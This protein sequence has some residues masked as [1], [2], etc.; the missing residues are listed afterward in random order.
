MRTIMNCFCNCH[1]VGIGFCDKCKRQ[2]KYEMDDEQIIVDNKERKQ[3]KRFRKPRR[4][5]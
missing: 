1:S 4:K 3:F 5:L 2:H